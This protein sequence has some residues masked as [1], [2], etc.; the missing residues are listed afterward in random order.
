MSTILAVDISDFRSQL[1][2]ERTWR[3]DELRLLENQIDGVGGEEE[4]R[5]YRKMLVVMLYSHFEGYCKI[6]LL[7]YANAINKAGF[8][9][10]DVNDAIA[11]ATLT[12]LFNATTSGNKHAFFGKHLPD[13]SALHTLARRIEFL[14]SI[15]RA[16]SEPVLIDDD[17]VNTGSNLKAVVLKKN[18]FQ[19]G[20]DHEMIEPHR[21]DLD[22]LVD[23]R[24]QLAHGTR[25]DGPDAAEYARLQTNTLKLME[26]VSSALLR[27]VETGQFRS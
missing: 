18:F 13:D 9:C 25:R 17:L 12:R 22:R 3:L 2:F 6:A 10:H 19:L 16:L 5:R 15:P 14:S 4:Q 8:R 27:A 20:L 21:V 7:V 23:E 26:A 11:A 24:N 1:E